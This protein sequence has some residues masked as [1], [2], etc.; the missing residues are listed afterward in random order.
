M[1]ETNTTSSRKKENKPL[2]CLDEWR[3]REVVISMLS[4]S[5][6]TLFLHKEIDCIFVKQQ[7]FNFRLKPMGIAQICSSSSLHL[8]LAIA[9][10]NVKCLGQKPG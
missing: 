8:G 9:K 6:S 4:C 10:F 7:F 1:L 5:P 2:S 3:N